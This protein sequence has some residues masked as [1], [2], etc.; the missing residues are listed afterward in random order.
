MNAQLNF[1]GVRRTPVILQTEARECGLACMAM[2]AGFHGHQIDLATLRA[3]HPSS[4]RGATMMHLMQM[5]HSLHLSPRPVKVEVED[6]QRMPLPAVLH[7]EFNHFVVL[8]R[9][10][11]EHY[12]IHDPAQGVCVLS[13]EDV[14]RCFTGVC[15]Q[16]TTTAEFRAKKEVQR[17]SLLALMGNLASVRGAIGQ[18]LAMA[19]A[20]EVFAVLAPFF[21]QWVVDQAIVSSDRDLLTVLGMGFLLL[22]LAQVAISAGREWV[23]MV[24]GTTLNV[25][26]VSRLFA[27]LLRLPME[28]FEKRHLGDIASRF[29]SLNVIQRTL[30]TSSI[31]ALLDGLMALVTVAVMVVYSGTLAT[32]VCAA[33]ACY[34]LLRIALYRPLVQAQDE[35]IAHAAKQQ[36]NFLETVRGMQSVKLFGR[37]LQRHT[38]HQNLLVNNFNANVRVQRLTILYHAV[39]AAL[40]GIENIA[41]V[42]VGAL[43]VMK[44][45]LSI[46]MLFAFAAFKLQFVTRIGAFIDK[47]IEF[48]TLRLHAERVA[49]VAFCTPEND[50]SGEHGID[51]L[52]A[53]IELRNVTFRYSPSEPAVL[54]NVSLKVAVGESVA[55]VGPS[56]CGKTTLLKVILG[57]LPPTEGEVLV[58]GVSISH[59]GTAHR[60]MIGT[61]MQ[62]DVLFA[63]SIADNI[64]CFDAEPNRK[65]IETCARLA[66]IH[67]D[68]QAM[69]MGFNTLIGDMGTALSGGQK[70]RVLLARALY[71]QPR[72]LALDEATSHLDVTCERNV[73]EAVH[74]LQ[75]TRLIIAHRPETIRMAGRVIALE[76]GRVVSHHRSQASEPTPART[77]PIVPRRPGCSHRGQTPRLKREGLA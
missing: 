62:E 8:T 66:A 54:R 33:A 69:P 5:A 75:L 35:Q 65:R 64:S 21:M 4:A 43:F 32:I 27:H 70:Q 11:G 22:A 68:I 77:L 40:F 39:K 74:A 15:L 6:L 13:F 3:Q 23:L 76:K 18:V 10:A 46:G 36:S 25:T 42:W 7:W 41:V 28:Y 19:V 58:G 24:L 49:D 31:E 29:E 61:V 17:V 52:P 34:G 12:T 63:G 73:N 1:R 44:G 50:H 26:M 60:Q 67:D 2:V 59:L 9:I 71:K 16:L 57:F 47:A 72:I 48:R 45:H 30:T 53:D 37:Q 56:G 20:L 55:L 14:S 51:A 38:V